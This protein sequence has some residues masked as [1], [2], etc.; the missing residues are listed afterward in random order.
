MIDHV[1]LVGVGVL[2]RAIAMRLLHCHQAVRVFNR[3]IAKAQALTAM[4][5]EVVESLDALFLHDRPLIIVCLTDADAIRDVFDVPAIKAQMARSRPVILNTSTIGPQES[6]WMERFFLS[7]GASYVECPVSGG[8][9]GALNGRLAAWVGPLPLD[10]L[11]RTQKVIGHLSDHFVMME[12]NPTAQ[13]MKVIN[14]YCEAVHLLVA[15]EVILLAEKSGI[16]GDVLS[17]ALPLG[18][19]RS[20]YMDVMLDRYLH[21]RTHVAVPIDIR[22]KDLELAEQLFE[23]QKMRSGFFNYSHHVYSST[24]EASS[25]PQDQTA[26][27]SQLEKFTRISTRRAER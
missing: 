8:P 1:S 19:G 21:P 18:R 11:A 25:Q 4:G 5:A 14:N 27:F 12:S 3:T 17:K 26:C 9:E 2:G 6:Q 13:A 10:D 16:S 7:H 22:L 15:A 20:I 24:Q 23:Q